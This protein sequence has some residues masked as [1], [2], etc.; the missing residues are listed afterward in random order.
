MTAQTADLPSDLAA[1]L[2]AGT[3]LLEMGLD[4][5]DPDDVAAGLEVYVRVA[6]WPPRRRRQAGLED[7]FQAATRAWVQAG[8]EARGRA[9]EGLH[10]DELVDLSYRL[11]DDQAHDEDL[12]VRWAAAAVRA[13]L[14]V[15]WL[16]P[17]QR[18]AV[19]DTI[20]ELRSLA[21]THPTVFMAAAMVAQVISQS[22]PVDLWPRDAAE[23]LALF[24]RLPLLAEVDGEL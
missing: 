17:D 2:I 22:E 11:A 21:D 1:G 23:L 13:A 4:D 24:R 9:F 16:D 6:A 18:V 3:E 7:A 19:Q 10:T 8:A 15:P 5:A 12:I 14:V 20:G